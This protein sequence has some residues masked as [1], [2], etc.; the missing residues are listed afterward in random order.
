[1]RSPGETYVPDVGEHEGHTVTVVGNEMPSERLN[2]IVG[3][4]DTWVQCECGA[5]WGYVDADYDEAAKDGDGWP[6]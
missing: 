3:H 4:F 6:V 5:A 1:M 2:K